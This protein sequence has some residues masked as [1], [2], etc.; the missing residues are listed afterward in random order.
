MEG[1]N[2]ILLILSSGDA[3]NVG[4]RGLLQLVLYTLWGYKF[5]VLTVNLHPTL[6]APP[7]GDAF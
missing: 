1:G 5:H 3:F 6:I 4:G 7:I 2:I